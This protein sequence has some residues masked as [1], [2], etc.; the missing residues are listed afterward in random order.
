MVPPMRV[1]AGPGSSVESDPS[2]GPVLKWWL[3]AGMTL[4]FYIV[5]SFIRNQFGSALGDSVRLR[6]YENALDIIGIEKAMGLYHE[7]WTQQQFL[8]WD[9]FVVFG[10]FFMGRSISSSPS[11]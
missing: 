10:T 7:E 1:E 6:S 5:Y 11:S 9:W 4:A 3:E 2:S 8:D